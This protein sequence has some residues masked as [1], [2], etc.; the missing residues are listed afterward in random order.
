M[1]SILV[2]FSSIVELRNHTLGL[3]TIHLSS[4]I[5]NSNIIEAAPEDNYLETKEN[6]N[7]EF[8]RDKIIK[9]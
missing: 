3:F 8:Y 6:L 7:S 9:S 5:T 1:E 2:F 4:T